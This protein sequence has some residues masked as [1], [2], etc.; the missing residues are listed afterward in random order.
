MRRLF[1]R[2]PYRELEKR[3]GYTFRRHRDLET[4]LTHRSFRFEN[5]ALDSDNQ[6]MEFLGDAVLGFVAGAYLYERYH[7][8]Q[9]GELTRIRSHLISGRMLAKLAR[10]AQVGTYVRIGKG[11]QKVGGHRRGSTLCDALEALIGAAYLDGGVKAVEKIFKTLF[12][13]ELGEDHL[14]AWTHNPKGE[15]QQLAQATWREGP[16]Y[17]V[18]QETGPAHARLFEVEV[19]VG[20]RRLGVGQGNSKRVAESRAATAALASLSESG[21]AKADGRRPRRGRRRSRRTS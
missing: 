20:E 3:L 14:E 21:S 10:K 1:R 5:P 15:L 12:V 7:D 9:E 4:A 16:I 6:R 8:Q 11:E 13:P 2:N 17:R 18:L 19:A